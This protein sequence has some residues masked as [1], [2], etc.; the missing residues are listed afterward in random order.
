MCH[1]SELEFFQA[2]EHVMGLLSKN[3]P[4][5]SQVWPSIILLQDVNPDAVNLLNSVSEPALK[6]WDVAFASNFSSAIVCTKHLSIQITDTSNW[7]VGETCF[8]HFLLFH[9]ILVVSTYLPHQGLDNSTFS[10]AVTELST[11][12]SIARSR[13]ISRFLVGGDLNCGLVGGLHR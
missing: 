5:Y 3:V 11:L 12:L 2:I 8:C 6:L 13:G 1:T 4:S 7:G 10:T 9:H